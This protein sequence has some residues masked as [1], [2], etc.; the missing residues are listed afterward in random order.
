MCPVTAW[1]RREG[2]LVEVVFHIKTAHLDQTAPSPTAATIRAGIS[3]RRVRPHR[4][5][6]FVGFDLE[7]VLSWRAAGPAGFA[8]QLRIARV[9]A[10]SPGVD[11]GPASDSLLRP[12]RQWCSR[13]TVED[14]D[15]R[16]R[17]RDEVPVKSGSLHPSVYGL[18]APLGRRCPRLSARVMRS[19]YSRRA[20]P[21]AQITR[22]C[23][24][25]ANAR[26]LIH[27]SAVASTTTTARSA[28]CRA[29]ASSSKL[30]SRRKVP[31]SLTVYRPDVSRQSLWPTLPA[32]GRRQQSG[33]V[34]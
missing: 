30:A 17:E 27:P 34:R 16:R 11:Q 10:A 9:H 4:R 20:G 28:R 12:R 13:S 31:A 25:R 5:A 32:I 19:R 1:T 21:I 8:Q 6:M 3:R 14:I 2:P 23:N 24:F 18:A 33:G 7:Q 22:S 26:P 29:P 15:W